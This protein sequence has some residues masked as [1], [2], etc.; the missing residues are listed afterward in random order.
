MNREQMAKEFIVL[1]E[2]PYNQALT[3]ELLDFRF[4][5][6]YEEALEISDAVDKII[7]EGDTPENKSNLLKELADLQYVLSGMAVTFGL[8]LEEAYKRVHKSNMSK[9]PPKYRE[10]GKILKGDGYIE[11]DLSD[12]V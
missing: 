6:I 3:T 11:P 2:Q 8:P 10:D 7:L 9:L 4:G 1:G 12:L 5:L